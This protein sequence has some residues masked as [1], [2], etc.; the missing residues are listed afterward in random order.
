[1]DGHPRPLPRGSLRGDGGDDR[2]FLPV[3]RGDLRHRARVDPRPGGG[4]NGRGTAFALRNPHTRGGAA[5]HPLYA[6][7]PASRARRG[8]GAV[9]YGVRLS[10]YH[11]APLEGDQPPRTWPVHGRATDVRRRRAR[12]WTPLG[13]LGVR[14]PRHRG[15]LL[16][17]R[18][19][20]DV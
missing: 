20:R 2:I 15:T 1:N 7:V 13:R 6:F 3:H 16:D 14:S 11:V 17:V 18:G 8:A 5:L 19:T 4:S 9:G 12:D 10:V